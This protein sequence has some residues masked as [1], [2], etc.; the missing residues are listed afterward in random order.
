ME[1]SKTRSTYWV[2]KSKID[3]YEKGRPLLSSVVVTFTTEPSIFV[4]QNK[5]MNIDAVKVKL[6]V[7][8]SSFV[9]VRCCFLPSKKKTKT[10]K[11]SSTVSRGV[12]ASHTSS[13]PAAGG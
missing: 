5:V 10:K 12:S 2:N 4:F 11:R 13:F 7:R 9:G 6:Q 1:R 3:I 8:T